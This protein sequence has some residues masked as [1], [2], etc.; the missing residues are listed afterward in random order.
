M[1]KKTRKQHFP[2]ARPARLERFDG[3]LLTARVNDW[4]DGR[5]TTALGVKVTLGGMNHRVPRDCSRNHPE[6]LQLVFS[7]GRRKG[8]GSE[9]EGGWSVQKKQRYQS[10]RTVVQP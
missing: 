1:V 10:A 2:S 8:C 3:I 4:N 6:V 5:A 7:K 9:P